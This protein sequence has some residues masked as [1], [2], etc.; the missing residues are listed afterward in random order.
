MRDTLERVTTDAGVDLQDVVL[1]TDGGEL[2]VGWT[3]DRAGDE[4]L[5]VR[6]LPTDT[7]P[8]VVRGGLYREN[9]RRDALLYGTGG[10]FG[11]IVRDESAAGVQRLQ[12][13]DVAV[14]SPN[15]L[16][17]SIGSFGELD[18]RQSPLGPLFVTGRPQGIFRREGSV[19]VLAA[20]PVLGEGSEGSVAALVD[21]AVGSVWLQTPP[22]A[23]SRVL[24]FVR[25]LPGALWRQD[26][27]T[28]DLAVDGSD[29]ALAPFEN[30][31]L[32]AFS[33]T[34]GGGRTLGLLALSGEGDLVTGPCRVAPSLPFANDPDVA[35]GGGWCAIAWME[36]SE[37][38]ATDYVT[39]VIQVPEDHDNLCP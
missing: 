4:A 3:E 23:T 31:A 7:A 34:D 2:A 28:V 12:Y 6:I 5:M 11:A 19:W 17:T 20:A 39:R 14:G 1:A 21:G 32:M 30:G 13:V 15:Y 22:L 10:G 33:Y 26:G 25:H 24:T 37:Y 36:A 8:R 9:D 18:I 27:S 35:C 38:A 16:G 29:P